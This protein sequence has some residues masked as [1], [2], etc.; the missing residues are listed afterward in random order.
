MIKFRILNN[1]VLYD[2]REA[3]KITQGIDIEENPLEE[4]KDL[5]R[6]YVKQ[7]VANHST[8]RSAKFRMKATAPKTAIM[9][10][11][12][13]TKGNPQPYVQSSRPD[14][15]GKERSNDPYEE[16]M[17]IMD[18]TPESFIDMCKQRLCNRTEDKTRK[19]VN[20]AVKTLK[21]SDDPLLKAVGYCSHPYCWWY[22]ACPELKSCGKVPHRVIDDV[23]AECNVDE[24]HKVDHWDKDHVWYAC[25]SIGE[26]RYNIRY[27]TDG[28]YPK[29]DVIKWFATCNDVMNYLEEHKENTI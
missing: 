22:K 11:I 29:N 27:S 7:I 23:L 25:R 12:R 15:T 26:E 10:V 6:F 3:C 28:S 8:I 18:F 1:N 19:F 17:F 14:W 20:E 4:P 24:H 5:F 13:A 21:E 16:K 2:Y 9:Q